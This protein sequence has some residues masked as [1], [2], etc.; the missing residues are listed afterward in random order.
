MSNVFMAVLYVNQHRTAQNANNH[1][2]RTAITQN[3]HNVI[4]AVYIVRTLKIVHPAS[5]A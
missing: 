5:M 4:M 3:A 1:F 2:S